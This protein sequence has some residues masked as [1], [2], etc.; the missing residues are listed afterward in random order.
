MP[1]INV[2]PIVLKLSVYL[3]GKGCAE[4]LLIGRETVRNHFKRYR[5]GGFWLDCSKMM[6]AAAMLRLL[7]NSSGY[8]D[9]HLR[10]NLY[11]AV[12]EVV[13]YVEQKLQVTYSESGMTQLLHRLTYVY[14]EPKLI[15][16][17]ANAESKK[18][19]R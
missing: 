14:K 16:G 11:L 8:L 18:G 4:T 3:L 6:L 13:H 15:Q 2:T 17:K 5:K 12:K 10:E 19:T 9:Q 7:R 1:P